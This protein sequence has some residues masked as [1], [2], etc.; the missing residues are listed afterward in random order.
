MA[1]A[2]S[3]YIISFLVSLISPFWGLVGFICSLLLRFQDHYPQIN[4]IKPFTL[5]LVGMLLSCIINKDQLSKLNWKQDKLILAMLL[6]S[7]VGL[8]IMEPA[9]LILETYMFL[10]SISIYYFSSRILQ[11]A[12]QF[13]TLFFCMALCVAYLGYLAIVDIALFPDTT[14]YIEHASNRWQGLGYYSN[15]NEFGQLMITTVPFLLACILIRKS[16][17][18]TLGSIFLMGIMF[19]VMLKC[20]SR[21]VISTVGLMFVG[22]FMLRGKGSM[23]KKA[24][25]GG[26][27]TIVML[28]V[29]MFMP[30]P[31]QDRMSSVLDAGNDESFQ[32]RTR[33]WDHG[34]AM[35]SWYPITGVGKGQWLEYH[36]LMP[37][38]SYVQIMAEMGVIGIWLYLWTIWR[39]LLQF[40]PLFQF[41]TKTSQGPP[42]FV[43]NL[44]LDL[45]SNNNVFN[46]ANTFEHSNYINS[47]IESSETIAD[48]TLS[49]V[50]R[51]VAIAAFVTFAG[52]LL[53]IFLG[54]QGYS[55]WTYFYL[56]LCSAL[57]NFMPIKD[58]KEESVN[59]FNE[60]DNE[61]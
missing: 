41:P 55:I 57:A 46:D 43:S 61:H 12:K 8:L 35:L 26:T 40:K 34:F 18:L 2:F 13:L 19:W 9:S 29:L 5:L 58:E 47:S 32:G 42:N 28:T 37:H 45:T 22:T 51:T 27:M 44:Q 54:N 14:L 36:G 59:L 11:T 49:N 3:Y 56:G 4:A 6:L 15:S 30:G 23:L 60:S 16:F 17:L 31:I 25:V 7:M 53:Y 1:F 52:W 39:C 38:N 24:L 50:E 10:C 20:E 48:S 33:S 21:T